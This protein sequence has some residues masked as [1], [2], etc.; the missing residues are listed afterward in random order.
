MSDTT[1]RAPFSELHICVHTTFC[2][3]G[4]LFDRIEECVDD[5]QFPGTFAKNRVCS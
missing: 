5:T 1:H 2:S 3:G 4:H